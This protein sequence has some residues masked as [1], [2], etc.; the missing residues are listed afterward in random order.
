AAALAL[1]L[2][3]PFVGVLGVAVG[4]LAAAGVAWAWTRACR[5]LL[6]GQTGDAI[7]ALHAL[8]EIAVLTAF[9]VLV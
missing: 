8:I 9:L 5:Q 2:A 7:G 3:G 1:M 4:G 6:G